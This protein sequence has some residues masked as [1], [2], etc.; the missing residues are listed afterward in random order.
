MKDL[1][2]RCFRRRSSNSSSGIIVNVSGSAGISVVTASCNTVRVSERH[3][4]HF[5]QHLE[6]VAEVF[7]RLNVGT[8]DQRLT[9]APRRRAAICCRTGA[10][11]AVCEDAVLAQPLALCSFELRAE[12]EKRPEDGE[13]HH[14][15][16]HDELHFEYRASLAPAKRIRLAISAASITPCA[17]S[18]GV[19]RWYGS[20]SNAGTSFLI[21]RRPGSTPPS[22]RRS[23][24]AIRYWAGAAPP[25]LRLRCRCRFLS[26][27][28]RI[29]HT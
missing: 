17:I 4:A 14:G 10:H 5:S 12:K 23:A 7:Q 26:G 6:A 19:Y 18:S 9:P 16:K 13:H 22:P 24:C 21:R 25:R 2:T 20:F 29:W 27:G 8:P 3:P 1:R 15:D 28:R 11:S